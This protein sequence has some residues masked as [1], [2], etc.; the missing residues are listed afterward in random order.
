M[1]FFTF[2]FLAFFAFVLIFN[3]ALKPWPLVWRIFLLGA[4]YYFYSVWDLRLLAVLAV[5]S[6]FNYLVGR[7]VH[8]NWGGKKNLFLALGIICDLLVLAFFKYYDFFRMLAESFSKLLGFAIGLPLLEMLV[9]VGISFYLF[10]IISFL[11]DCRSSKIGKYPSLLDFSLYVAF[12][13]QL[14]SGP[15]ARAQEFLPQLENG[16][17]KKIEGLYLNV[18]LIMVGLF[19]KLL[20]VNYLTTNI[21]DDVFVVPQNHGSLVILLAILAYAL[22]IY[23]DLSSYSDMAIGFAGLLGFRTP[24]NFDHPYAALTIQEFWRKWHITLSNWVKDYI[25]IPLGGNRKGKLRQ[26]ANLVAAMTAMGF[27]HG[28]GGHYIFWGFLHGT[29]LGITEFFPKLRDKILSTLQGR[30]FSWLATFIFVIFSWIFFRVESV[31]D[32]FAMIGQLFSFQRLD[33]SFKLYALLAVIVGFVFLAFE[34]RIISFGAKIQQ[35]MPRAA[36]IVFVTAVV[37]LLF[38]AGSDTLP[39]FIYFNF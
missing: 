16:G 25:Y 26:A 12:F 20:I 10:K 6:V 24:A 13:P 30:F 9:A 8:S 4:S 19:K 14:L 11:A 33:E 5:L 36:W 31:S 37:A 27:W 1:I 39:A 22:V 7:A 18:T 29:A 35:K 34:S 21:T 23:F 17:A 28:S 2:E 15:I 32:G 3:W 38:R